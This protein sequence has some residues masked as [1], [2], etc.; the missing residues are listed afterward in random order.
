MIRSIHYTPFRTELPLLPPDL[1]GLIEAFVVG[2][3]AFVASL[4]LSYVLPLQI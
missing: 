3:Q 2:R 4:S 1:I